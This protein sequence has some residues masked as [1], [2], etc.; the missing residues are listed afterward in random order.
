MVRA[1]YALAIVLSAGLSALG[2]AIAN[3]SAPMPAE[4]A[5]ASPVL[6]AMIAA[7]TAQL[8]SWNGG[9]LAPKGRQ[10]R[11]TRY[12]WGTGVPPE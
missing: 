3:G 12:E 6:V 9:E 7:G 2:V 11:E 10:R 1:L 4:W 5:W 8:P